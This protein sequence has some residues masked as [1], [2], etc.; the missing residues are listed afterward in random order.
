MQRVSA[1]CISILQVGAT[2][3][4]LPATQCH[5]QRT[6]EIRGLNMRGSVHDISFFLFCCALRRATL[7]HSP[8]SKWY[9]N[10]GEF[11]VNTC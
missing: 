8:S 6:Q 3:T 7:T 11:L 10:D 9:K 1:H 2:T 5:Q 4:S